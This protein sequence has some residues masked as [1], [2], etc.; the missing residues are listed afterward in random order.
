MAFQLFKKKEAAPS[1]TPVDR[2]IDLK[3]QGLSNVQ[4]IQALQS[5]GFSQ[6]QILDA[7]SQAD[8]KS[9]FEAVPG[10][11]QMAGY[12]QYPSYEEQSGY[13]SAGYPAAAP[14]AQSIDEGSMKEKI[15]EV[16]EAII[17]EKWTDLVSNVGRIAD[18]KEKTEARLASMET[19]ISGL[20]NDFDK[21]HT[22]ILERITDYEKSITD[23]GTEIKA[24]EK[25][26]QKILPGFVENVQELSRI[27]SNIKSGNGKK[28]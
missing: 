19:Q 27:T 7:M 9:T 23:V 20:R 11:G 26:F 15:S 2:V 8:I 6:Q 14:S 24:L 5:E 1:A 16:A 21:L 22:A 4:I 10:G 13:P 25:V 12:G 28:K 17:E 18:W 3:R